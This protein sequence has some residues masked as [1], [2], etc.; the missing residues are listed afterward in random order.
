MDPCAS[1]RDEC[2][3]LQGKIDSDNFA[4]NGI[5]ERLPS[6]LEDGRIIV[7]I[8]GHYSLGNISPDSIDCAN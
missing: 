8:I 6:A 4:L 7:G 2:R 3:S 5:H 1:R